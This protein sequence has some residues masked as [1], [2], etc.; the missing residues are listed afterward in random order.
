MAATASPLIAT[1][2]AILSMTEI[3]KVANARTKVDDYFAR[4]NE[5]LEEIG[6]LE[7]TERFI[8]ETAKTIDEL[9]QEKEEHSEIIQLINKDK[10]VLEREIAEAES[11]KK[12]REAKIQKKY[13][14]LLKLMEQT[15][16]RLKESGIDVALSQ[17]DLPQTNIKIEPSTA[18]ATPILTGMPTPFANF[19]LSKLFQQP[20]NNCFQFLEQLGGFAPTPPTQFRAPP[21]MAAAMQSHQLRVTDHQS[22]PMKTCQSCFQQ[23]HRNAPICPMCKSKSRSKNPKKPKRKEP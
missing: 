1:E 14:M 6:E 18:S 15:N 11:E 17:E 13:E 16:E 20:P 4:R 19:N 23:I 12:E 9:N 21:H 10:G 2:S 7:N 8:K 22:P 3:H 5:L